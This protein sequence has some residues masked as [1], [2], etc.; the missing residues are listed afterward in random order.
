ARRKKAKEWKKVTFAYLDAR[1]NK[2]LARQWEVTCSHNCEYLVFNEDE[3]PA[4]I[5]SQF[6]EAKLLEELRRFLSPAVTE[7]S[8]KEADRL[9]ASNV[10]ALFFGSKDQKEYLMFK[11]AANRMRGELAFAAVFGEGRDH[12]ELWT[13]SEPMTLKLADFRD[14]QTV[15]ETWLRQRSVPLL[16]EYDWMKRETYER[17]KLPLARVWYDD[18]SPDETFQAQVTRTV[19]AVAK[20]LLGR[21]AFVKQKKSTYSYELRD[22]GLTNPEEYP[23]F[24]IAENVSWNCRKFGLATGAFAASAQAFWSDEEL[25]ESKLLEFCEGAHGSAFLLAR[26]KSRMSP[27]LCTRTGPKARSS[28]SS[29]RAS[30]KRSRLQRCSKQKSS[31]TDLSS[32]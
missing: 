2:R 21:M 27:G 29:G 13:E 25:S 23:A 6:E 7:V 26:L 18:K 9:K 17:M 22:Y 32:F 11:R 20:K 15:L 16:Q 10:T 3:E 28:E 24:G 12:I 14:N 8:Q 19:T 4:R 1:E 30:R 5:K 31:S